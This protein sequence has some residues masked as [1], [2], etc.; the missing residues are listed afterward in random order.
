MS[1][2]GLL[3]GIAQVE[4]AQE[5]EV[6]D[7]TLDS[8]EVRQ[9]SCFLAVRGT[10]ENA[11][12]HAHDAVARG[13]VAIVAECR[14][15]AVELGIPVIDVPGLRGTLGTLAARFFAA[16]SQAVRVFAVTGTNGKTTVAHLAAQAFGLL[17]GACGYIGTLGA[18]WPD[19]L[20]AV[21][22]TTPDIVTINRWLARM[23]GAGATAATLEASSHALDQGRL[24]GLRLRAAAFTNLGH[25]HL[26]YHGTHDAY[27]AAKARLFS[28]P[29]LTAA[30][31]NVDDACGAA[32]AGAL[33]P[34]IELWTCSSKAAS[35]STAIRPRLCARAIEVNPAGMAFSLH[36]DGQQA[37][38]RS[39]LVGRFNVDNLL[40]IAGL[41]L[42]AGHPLPAVADC[43]GRLRA[44]PGRM[45][46]CGRSARGAAVFVDYAHSPD[47]LAAALSTLRE[48][49]RG[50]LHVVF[51]CGGNRDR[52][53][54]GPM[55][56]AAA[57]YADVVI[58]TDDNP[59]D[60]DPQV[61]AAEILAGIGETVSCAVIGDRAAAIRRALAEAADGDT[62]LIAGKGHESVQ[63][64]RGQRRDFSDRDQ[65]RAALREVVS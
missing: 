35:E 55:G 53:K 33:R 14:E 40:V 60:E 9:G 13:A 65:V 34:G 24:D 29:G 39:P 61:I 18:G 8:R 2:S 30:V 20:E 16:P 7:I 26:D 57:R 5:R 31:V 38:V 58:V 59:R 28:Q 54:R 4:P 19:D 3:A 23:Q 6:R 37:S 11:M 17:D 21:V 22:N 64:V 10:R 56:A 49:T 15:E 45:E 42:A 12:R 47:S 44:V 25:D 52:S 43:L 48:L 63:E 46:A 1:L 51:G 36:V 41:L 62:V 50:R 27:A 32:I